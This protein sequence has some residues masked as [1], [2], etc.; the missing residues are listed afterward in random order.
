MHEMF[1]ALGRWH[2]QSRPDR[3]RYVRI[4][5]DNIQNGEGGRGRGGR[6]RRGGEE[7]EKL[8]REGGGMIIFMIAPSLFPAVSSEWSELE[9]ICNS[10]PCAV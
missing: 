6:G 5:K 2:E 4:I 7:E 10:S 9:H 1:H 3:D 8:G